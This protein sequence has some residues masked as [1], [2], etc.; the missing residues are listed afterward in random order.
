M[1]LVPVLDLRA[2]R[3]VRAVG[4]R[5]AEYRPFA[6]DPLA[7]ARRLI[8]SAGAT[9]LYV[10]DLDA[11]QAVGSNRAVWEAFPGELGVRVVVDAGLR[12]AADIEAFPFS[13]GLVPIAASETLATPE[14][15]GG[16]QD[17]SGDAVFSVDSHA[18]QLLGPWQEWR[19]FGVT[20]P[21]DAV[22]M[23]R[24][25]HALTGAFAVILL[26]LARV[27]ERGGPAE[28][29]VAAVRGA[30][31]VGVA[32]WVGGGVRD[33]SDLRRLGD[34]GVEGVLVSTALHEGGL[35]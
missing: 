19:D 20:G 5:R 26:D 29:D 27:G 18:G 34:L 35:P 21:R 6:E 17:R 24:A 16:M 8:E 28:D 14:V 32:L 7:L 25:G 1:H 23:A 3:A 15:A 33:R 13:V 12:T 30:L 4:G 10:A 2:G 22:G 31:P 11:I 9:S